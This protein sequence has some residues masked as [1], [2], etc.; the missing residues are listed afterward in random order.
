MAKLEILSQGEE[1]ITGQ[2]VDTNAAWLAQQGFELGFKV[3]RQSSVGDNLEDLVNI[4]REIS[5]RSDCC[6]CTGGL[7]P[8]TDDLTAEAFAQAFNRPL[9][10]DEVAFAH[11]QQYFS[12]RNRPMADCN[13][14]QAMLPQVSI[15]LDN[16][17]GTAPGFAAKAGVCWFVF[18]PGVPGEMKTMFTHAVRHFLLRQFTLPPVNLVTIRTV[19]VGESDL[20]QRLNTIDLPSSVQLGF[21]AEPGEVQV[22]LLFSPDQTRSRQDELTDRVT[23]RIGPPVYT[24]N[25]QDG[26][27]VNLITVIDSLMQKKRL[28]LVLLETVSHGLAAA[29][30]AGVPWLSKADLLVSPEAYLTSAGITLDAD[31]LV[32]VTEQLCRTIRAEKPGVI[33]IAQGLTTAANLALT[34]DKPVRVGSGLLADGQF[35]YL[36]SVLS[37]D[38]IRRQNQAATALFDLLRR[39]LQQVDLKSLL[40]QNEETSV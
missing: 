1:I 31:D 29:K 22:K 20:Q 9:I 25:R 32:R 28:I 19:G 37:G 13:R 33:T 7:G 35:Y 38:Y 16:A 6:L 30:M 40:P 14:K 8:T 17:T 12:H 4:L 15:R 26:V 21:R 39:Y 2:V 3:T 27:P 23:Q 10:F 11:I 24:V 34:T 5:R 36:E 18:M